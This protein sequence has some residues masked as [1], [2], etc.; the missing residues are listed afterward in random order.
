MATT[1]SIAARTHG[2]Y[3]VE[4]GPPERLLVGFHGYGENADVSLAE[5]LKIPG[6]E[7]W[8]VVAVQALHRFYRGRTPTI[9][10]SWM[11]S[12]DRERAITD[13]IDYVRSVVAEFPTPRR[14]VFLGFSQGV[15]MA[16]R[17]A[18]SHPNANGVIAL[19]GE[20]TPDIAGPLPP[21]L[22]GRGTREDWYTD[23]KLKKDLSILAT[24]T[25]VETCIFD[26]GHEWTEEFRVAAGR[27][28]RGM[29]NV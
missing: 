9:A 16:Y 29:L 4:E 18:Y 19:A 2:R 7:Q 6:V 22:I 10:A 5:M 25:T 27:F 3:L 14:L 13:N 12:Q 1:Y 15:A 23:E 28:L 21:V 20:V 8:T 24:I 17:A 11:T 26:G